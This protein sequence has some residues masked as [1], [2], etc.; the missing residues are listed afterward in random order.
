MIWTICLVV[1]TQWALPRIQMPFQL[2]RHQRMSTYLALTK[3]RRRR[4]THHSR[5]LKTSTPSHLAKRISS[6]CQ[7]SRT[8]QINP[9]NSQSSSPIQCPKQWSSSRQWW[10]NRC[11]TR[12]WCKTSWL[13]PCVNSSWPSKPWCNKTNSP[14]DSRWW[15]QAKTLSW[16]MCSLRCSLIPTSR[17]SSNHSTNSQIIHTTKCPS[18]TETQNRDDL[19]QRNRTTVS[20]DLNKEKTLYA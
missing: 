20:D 5:S 16:R 15:T 1:A 12:T 14:P 2:S 11:R 3:L 19:L 10:C 8:F 18:S 17:I 4:T 6:P 13:K 9:H 7:I